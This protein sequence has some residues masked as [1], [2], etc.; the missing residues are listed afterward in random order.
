MTKSYCFLSI[1]VVSGKCF[2][3]KSMT[4]NHVPEISCY[5]AKQQM[6]ITAF[7]EIK[8]DESFA[9]KSKFE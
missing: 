4:V 2:L 1:S 8:S 7:L 5:M 3:C 9:I 6:R